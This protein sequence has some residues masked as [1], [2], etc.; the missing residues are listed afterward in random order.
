MLDY[1]A[2]SP[3]R[4]PADSRLGQDEHRILDLLALWNEDCAAL[5]RAIED[6]TDWG[7]FELAEMTPAFY[8]VFGARRILCRF[9]F[10]VDADAREPF[11]CDLR[12]RLNSIT[13]W[14]DAP[15]TR[16]LD[17]THTENTS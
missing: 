10:H 12:R 8:D 16:L 1:V 6:Q 11:E 4:P 5:R 3:A 14:K 13:S 9:I 17:T 2:S 15:R 7:P